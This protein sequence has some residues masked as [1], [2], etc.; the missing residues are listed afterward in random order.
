MHIGLKKI[1]VK[2]HLWLGLA[3][4]LLV[5]LISISGAMYAFKDEIF[6]KVHYSAQHVPQVGTAPLPLDSLWQSAQKHL[7][8]EHPVNFTNTFS[9][10]TRTWEFRSYKYNAEKVSYFNWCEYD[11]IVYVNPYTAQVQHVLNHKTEFFQLVKMFH[12][13]FW[14]NTKIG[15]PI[16]GWTVLVFL[17]GLL[18]GLVLWWPFGKKSKKRAFMIPATQNWKVLNYDLHNVLGFYSLP[19][20]IVLSLTGMVWAFKWFMALVY[21]VANLSTARPAEVNAVSQPMP[22]QQVMTYDTIYKQAKLNHATAYSI[23]VYAVSENKEATIDTYIKETKPVY[24]KAHLESYDK[25]S[26]ERINITS[27]E[28]LSRGEKLL[29]MNYDIHVG[30]ILGLPG[31]IIAFLV[32]LI[33][34]SLPITGFLIWWNKRKK[35]KLVINIE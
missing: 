34:A 11:F 23:S 24:Y 21:V 27:F 15:Q 4:G 13:S 20:A 5:F 10:P 26:G 30:A 31:K 14:L 1:I 28:N 3:S 33:S 6:N 22:E 2:I 16:V 19:F 35:K 25:Y 12:W 32:A 8:P 29:R 18:S 7:G 17:I 9:D